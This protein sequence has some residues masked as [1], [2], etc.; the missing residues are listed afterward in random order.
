M[1]R[2]R[3]PRQRRWDWSRGFP[4][5]WACLTITPRR[6]ACSGVAR[7]HGWNRTLAIVAGDPASGLA[8]APEPWEID[9]VRGPFRDAVLPGYWLHIVETVTADAVMLLNAGGY[10]IDRVTIAGDAREF[11]ETVATEMV[12]TETAR[13]SLSGTAMA[14]AVAA[15]V[16]PDLFVALDLVSPPQLQFANNRHAT[17]TART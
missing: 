16:H 14:A 12:V 2:S 15:A 9:G 13:P 7:G 8:F 1:D 5:R 6:W 3:R 11:R 4:W 17:E 10:A